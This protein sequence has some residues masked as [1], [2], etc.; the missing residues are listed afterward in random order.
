MVETTRIGQQRPRLSN[1]PAG[2]VNFDAGGEIIEFAR[3][4]GFELDDWQQWVV[5]HM[6]AERAD[7]SWAAPTSVLL[8]PRQNGKSV[9]LEVLEL[10]ALFL[11]GE[12]HIIY[13]AHLGKTATDHMRRIAHR[14]RNTPD[15]HRLARVFTARG[16]ER[17]ER[18]DTGAI[19]E[20]I[21]RSRKTTRGGSPSRVLFDEAMF[22]TDDQL[23]AMVPALSAQSLNEDSG[24]QMIYASS[25]PIYESEVLHRLRKKAIDD[26]PERMFFCEWSVDV[27][28]D[29][30]DWDNWFAANPAMGIRIAPEWVQDTELGV[31]SDEAFM[32]ERLGIPQGGD[33]TAGVVPYSKWMELAIPQPARMESVTFGLAVAPDGSWS[34]VGSAGRLPSGDLYVDNVQFGQGS[35]WVL[36]RLIQL[37]EKHRKPIRVDPSGSEGAFIRPLKDA[38]IEVVE[39]MG[40]EYQQACGE[41]LSAVEN[42]KIRHIDQKALNVAVAAAGRRDVGKEGGWVWVRPGAVDI[43]PL[44][45]ATLALS[46]V[47]L[48]RKPKIHV[49]KGDPKELAAGRMNHVVPNPK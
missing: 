24:A 28:A 36:D 12:R 1:I 47:E 5:R 44:K 22:L 18:V 38:G 16:D 43:S 26:R 48:K 31:L 17:I 37:Y 27:D 32:V 19:L 40:R 4:Y 29:L 34:S 3:R 13:S 15:F 11:Y 6:V 20:F 10:A 45:A 25:A 23:Q 9:I 14:V 2:I 49:W 7:G 35:G 30:R 42:G 8:V 21:T 41:F 46:G 33:G 39:V